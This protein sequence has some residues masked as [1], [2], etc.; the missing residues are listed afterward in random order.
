[1]KNKACPAADA[2]A[3]ELLGF[4][5]GSR[6]LRAKVGEK[7]VPEKLEPPEDFFEEPE[8]DD[9][10]GGGKGGGGTVE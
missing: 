5:A 10:N 1:M 3:E 9:E 4:G 7:P 6:S 8:D 2:M